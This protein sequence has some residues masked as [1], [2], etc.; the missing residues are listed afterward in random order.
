MSCGPVDTMRDSCREGKHSCGQISKRLKDEK[1]GKG[2]F[3]V[4][5][6]QKV[7]LDLQVQQ[8]MVALQRLLT[9]HTL[10]LS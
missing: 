1:R 4:C 2:G 5:P 10:G 7:T 6:L 3:K 9:E 8:G